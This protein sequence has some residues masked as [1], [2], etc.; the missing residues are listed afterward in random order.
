MKPIINTFTT[1]DATEMLK[2]TPTIVI[3]I[4]HYISIDIK[5]WADFSAPEV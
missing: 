1:Q 4:H 3:A 2:T 5:F